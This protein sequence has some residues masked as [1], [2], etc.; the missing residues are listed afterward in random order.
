VLLCRLC[1]C[2][3]CAAVTPPTRQALE[4]RL[5][6]ALRLEAQAQQHLLELR[7]SASQERT[8]GE[9]D[10]KYV[11]HQLHWPTLSCLLVFWWGGLI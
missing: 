1:C 5:L 4:C 2:A 9:L 11:A 6:K 10:T 3:A 7:V 8:T